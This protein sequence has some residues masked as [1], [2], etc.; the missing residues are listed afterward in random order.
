MRDERDTIDSGR[1]RV[2][3]RERVR[4]RE[5]DRYGNRTKSSAALKLLAIAMKSQLLAR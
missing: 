2:G 5:R 4:E 1:E 3:E